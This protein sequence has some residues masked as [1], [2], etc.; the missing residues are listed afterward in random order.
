MEYTYSAFISYRHLPKDITAAKA[1]QKALETYRIPRDIQKRTGIKKLNRC[2]RDQDELPLADDLGE[3]IVKALRESEWLIVICTPDLPKSKWCC[4][5]VETFIELGRKDRIIPVLVDGEPKDSYPPQISYRETAQGVE[6][7][8]PLAADLRGSLKKQLKTEKMR[9]AARML[10]LDFNDLKK[11]E[12]ERALRRGLVLVSGAFAIVAAFAG[13]ALY[14][15]GL[16]T[17]ERNQSARNA[18]EL[19]I[20]KSVRSTS[21]GEIGSGLTYALQAYESSRLFDDE[22]DAPVLAALETA[23]YPEPFSQI[24]SLKD[25][26][27]LHRM[28]TISNDGKFIACRQSDWSLQ[29]YNSVTGDRLYTLRDHRS[30]WNDA[31]DISPDCRYVSQITDNEITLFDVAD[32]T[33]VLTGT[34]PEGWQACWRGL[35]LINEIPVWSDEGKAGLY[36]PFSKELHI[37]E[38]ISREDVPVK[39]A[40][41][42]SGTRGFWYD[43]TYTYLVDTVNREILL[44]LDISYHGTSCEYTD[45]GLYFRYWDGVLYHYL[46][47]D[48]LEEVCQSEKFGSLSPD[49]KILASRSGS[50]RFTLWD[51][52]SGEAISSEGYNCLNEV[53]S[54][55]FV[56]DDTLI[57]SHGEVQIYKLSTMEVIYHSGE[58]RMTYGLDFAPGRL[59]MPLRSGGCLVNL[60]PEEEDILPH[61]TLETRQ[62]YTE[63]DLFGTTSCF[64]LVGNWQ[65]AVYYLWIDGESFTVNFDEPGLAYIFNNEEY[66]LHPVNGAGNGF[67]YVSP[68]GKWQAVIRDQE[69]DIFRAGEQAEP[70]MTIPGNGY[71]RLC[72]AFYGDIIALGS[73]VE[74]LVLYDL[75][76]GDCIGTVK[77]GAMC[78]DIQF[79]PDGKHLI[80]L[81]GMSEQA[82]VA[83]TENLAVIMRIPVTEIR[84][85]N[86]MAVGF[87]EDGTEAIIIYHDGH[88]DVALMN[89]DLRT[90]VEKAQKYTG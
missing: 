47:W 27:V 9:L 89:Q 14:Q 35:T 1:V 58:D 75:K 66:I 2:F 40:L 87:N 25:N 10:N 38:G 79:S 69:V 22:Y 68:D 73:Y 59:V 29:V 41:H 42:R 71:Q 19:L 36:D 88:A 46:R 90:L 76:T 80:G 33:Q 44:T 77:T 34:L 7:V 39:A 20:E 63:D 51:V 85:I 18:T 86:Q 84:M 81:S 61:M 16:L 43:G 11:R 50:D 49:E 56:D 48:T 15:N 62:D 12:R 31:P 70:V 60:L 6:E 67:V 72:A 57:A 23:M 83:N 65:G 52:S 82:V 32:G 24:G 53:Y 74:N 78:T 55:Y 13:Y 8:E 45:D 30:L 17:E 37:L 26:G 5:E 64:P 28:A 4:R 54:L 21:E 3:S